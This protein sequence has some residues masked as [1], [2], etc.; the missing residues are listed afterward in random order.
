[1][2]VNLWL[3][4]AARRR[5]VRVA[6]AAVIVCAVLSTGLML[7]ASAATG[8]AI[9]RSAIPRLRA[10]A[11]WLASQSGDAHPV[12]VR[13]VT[14]THASA[15][16]AATPGDRVTDRL[17]EAVY[18]VLMH[19]KFTLNDVPTPA[20]GHAPTGTYLAVVLSVNGMQLM[21]LGLHN[22]AP[23]MHLI[24]FGP[25]SVLNRSNRS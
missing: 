19:G 17:H 10:Y 20:G 9:P 1:M 24:K 12:W 11:S 14:T 16:Q 3:A 8:S 7:R 15:L 13:A 5:A 23:P 25:V 2:F 18:L 4:S 21:D 22:H 6:A